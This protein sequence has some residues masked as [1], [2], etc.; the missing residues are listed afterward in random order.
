[1]G[2]HEDPK[3]RE[4]PKVEIYWP[5]KGS[6]HIARGFDTSPWHVQPCEHPVDNSRNESIDTEHVFNPSVAKAY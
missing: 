2:K 6:D 3:R 5:G 1:M 4:V